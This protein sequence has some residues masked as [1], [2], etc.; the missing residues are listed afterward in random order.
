VVAVVI[1]DIEQEDVVIEQLTRRQAHRLPA[2]R[3][4]FVPFS[5]VEVEVLPEDE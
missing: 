4:V 3:I 5:L 2:G 1:E